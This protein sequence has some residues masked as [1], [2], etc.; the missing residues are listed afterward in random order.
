VKNHSIDQSIS[1]LKAGCLKIHLLELGSLPEHSAILSQN[2]FSENYIS[3]KTAGTGQ[4]HDFPD[5]TIDRIE[6]EWHRIE[7]GIATR[8]LTQFPPVWSLS[9]SENLEICQYVY[10]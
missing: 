9:A 1:C 2:Y 6:G 4:D 10:G 3:G 5:E 8:F 7:A